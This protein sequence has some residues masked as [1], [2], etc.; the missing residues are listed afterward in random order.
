MN[1]NFKWETENMEACLTEFYLCNHLK[2]PS[3]AIQFLDILIGSA[4]TTGI[5]MKGRFSLLN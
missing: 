2:F 3:D 4:E 1:N 5:I